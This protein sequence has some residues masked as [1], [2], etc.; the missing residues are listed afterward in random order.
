MMMYGRGP[1]WDNRK[2]AGMSVPPVTGQSSLLYFI[3]RLKA[4]CA[5]PF[6][7]HILLVHEV[8]MDQEGMD[9]VKATM[10]HP[11]IAL[12]PLSNL[13]I[14]NAL[15]P[16]MLMRE[17]GLKL[18]VGTDSLSSNDDLDPVAELYCL[19]AHFPAVSTGELLTWACRNGA[20]FLLRPSLGTLEAGRKPGLVLIDGLD[21]RGGLTARSRSKRLV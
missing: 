14:H 13:F 17:N 7:G 5:A 18:C 21:E 2:A 15:P 3:D 6:Y 10:R 8:C 16:V 11:F 1:M 4:A 12:C 19:Q 20:E 9:A